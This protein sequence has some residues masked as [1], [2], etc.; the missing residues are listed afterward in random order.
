M[1]LTD[2]AS[3]LNLLGEMQDQKRFQALNWRG[4]FRDYLN[5]VADNPK[6]TRNSFQRLYDMIMSYGTE[7]FEDAKKKLTR[8]KFFSDPSFDSGDAIYGLEIP[9]MRLVNFFKAAAQGYGTE[10]RVLLLFKHFYNS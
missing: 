10:K 2:G 4:T 5:V 8:F 9:L 3:L 6:V 7:D 1:P